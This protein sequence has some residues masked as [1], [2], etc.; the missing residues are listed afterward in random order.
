VSYGLIICGAGNRLDVV[1]HQRAQ[2]QQAKRP[3]GRLKWNKIWICIHAR[4]R[5]GSR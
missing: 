2:A 3:F 5:N 4:Y 1:A